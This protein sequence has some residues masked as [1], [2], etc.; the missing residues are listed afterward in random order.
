MTTWKIDPGHSEVNFRV[1]HLLVSTVRGNFDNFNAAI[2]TSNEDFSDAKIKFEADVNSINT[3]NEQR[4]THLKSAD[5]F[6]AENHPKMTFE[7]TSVKVVSDHEMKVK[8]MLT[9]RGVTKEI[10]LDV[11]YNGIVSGFGDVKVAGFEVNAKLNRFDYGLKWNTLTEAGG[12]VVS[13]EV[14]I[15]ILAEFNKVNEAVKAA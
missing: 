2:E 3:K 10:T 9:L 6:D 7:S 11:I 5:F 4:D 1:K 8:G 15:E 14:K 13:N 12:V